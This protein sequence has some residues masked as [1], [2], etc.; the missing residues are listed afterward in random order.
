MKI[1]WFSIV[2]TPSGK[3]ARTWHVHVQ[4]KGFQPFKGLFRCMWWQHVKAPSL[5]RPGSASRTHFS[6]FAPGLR[7]SGHPEYGT[8][9]EAQCFGS[10]QCREGWFE[11][12]SIFSACIYLYI[13]VCVC[14]RVYIYIHIYIYMCVMYTRSM[15]CTHNII[16]KH[17][18][19]MMED[20]S[21]E[22]WNRL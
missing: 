22:F 1:R 14:M 3:P 6:T 15:T 18:L 11:A 10:P 5:D 13:I 9:C 20:D 12:L 19:G 2:A 17:G 4:R 8:P 21:P 7:G 16:W